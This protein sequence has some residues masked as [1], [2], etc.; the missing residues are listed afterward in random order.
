MNSSLHVTA[1][2]SA[3]LFVISI[4]MFLRWM[5]AESHLRLPPGPNRIPLLG[6][7]HQLPMQSQER[8]FT[9]WGAE[10]A[11][12]IVFAKLF[13]TPTLVINSLQ[14]AQELLDKRSS[15]YSYRPDFILLSDLMGWDCVITHMTYGDRF[16]KHRRWISNAFQDKHS[17]GS[18][19]PLQRREAYMLLSG[20]LQS[21]ELFRSHIKRFAAAMILQIAYGHSV[22]SLDD[23]FIHLA[24]RAGKETVEYGSAG[25]MLVDLFPFLK[26]IPLWM[27]GSGFKSRAF[28]IRDL[29]RKMLDT[30]FEMVK[31][32][33]KSGT[34][35]PCL[36]ATLLE[37]VLS[38]RAPTAEDE[39]DIKGTA[40]VLYGAA[41]DTTVAV[42]STFILAMV[43]HP[44]VYEKAQAEV[45]RVVGQDRLPE[46]EDRE[47]LPYL[48]CVVKEVFRWNCPV[49][50]G[51]PHKLISNDQ[52]QGFDIPGGSMVIPNIWGM[53]RNDSFYPE[54]EMFR[55]ER[56]EQMDRETA[57]ARDP[58]K[59]VFGFGRR[60]C[61]GQDF[62]DASIWIAIA[63]IVA[64]LDIGVTTDEAGKQA[65]PTGSFVPGLVSHP[66]EFSCKITPRSEQ[67][68]T[69]V[70]E[71]GANV[72]L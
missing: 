2:A 72:V 27:P 20:L 11:G 24:E 33:M 36:T 8:K 9:Q 46:F 61:P 5:K 30:P 56:F 38:K 12:D 58:R 65:P 26:H 59:M 51:L 1:C 68:K 6:N 66:E 49:P 23:K 15:K 3:V 64:T 21:P 31:D 34:A 42:L 35:S 44:E 22:T 17:L 14:V 67:V 53:T 54:P 52:Y 37:E 43:L 47:S 70:F 32:A 50:L 48:E 10:Y 7:V 18:Y 57:E 25:V 28:E 69:V 45:D 29:V 19:R 60:I 39:D 71:M 13:K 41:T 63:S 40:G 4:A 16:R 55:P 62:A